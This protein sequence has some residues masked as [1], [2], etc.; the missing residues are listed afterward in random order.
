MKRHSGSP[1]CGDYQRN[2][3]NGE[4]NPAP[5]DGS[6]GDH[7]GGVRIH[8]S[9]NDFHSSPLSSP[10]VVATGESNQHAGSRGVTQYYAEPIPLPSGSIAPVPALKSLNFTQ[11]I[12]DGLCVVFG[13]FFLAALFGS[14]PL[15]VAL[16]V[17]G[18]F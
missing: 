15:A 7:L 5:S 11:A 14:L 16:M 13:L 3:R 17:L 1:H 8:R 10:R 9:F 2:E 18:V 6:R 4:R 12:L